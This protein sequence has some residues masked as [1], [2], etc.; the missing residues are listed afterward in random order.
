AL[1]LGLP[2]DEQTKSTV[3]YAVYACELA[4]S[5]VLLARSIGFSWLMATA[6]AQLYLY[7]LFPPFGSVFQIYNWYGL[8]P[9]FAHFAA[10]LNAAAS[11]FSASGRRGGRCLSAT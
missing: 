8:A 9:Y 10:A 6:G 2:L 1:A 3:S 5:I 4:V 7:L 11:A